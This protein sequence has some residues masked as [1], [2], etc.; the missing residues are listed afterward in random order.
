MTR[1]VFEC[2]VDVHN[3]Q[4]MAVKGL[5]RCKGFFLNMLVDVCVVLEAQQ[6]EHLPERLLLAYRLCY[7]DFK[8]V[9]PHVD[10]I[11]HPPSL[12]SA[13]AMGE[14]RES[15]SGELRASREP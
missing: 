7:P 12:A 4:T 2:C 10:E 1:G 13:P 14:L 11:L 8:N 6:V 3:F 9:T 5:N 15:Q